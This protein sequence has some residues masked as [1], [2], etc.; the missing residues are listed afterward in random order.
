MP[1]LARATEERHLAH[2]RQAALEQTY[3]AAYADTKRHPDKA[4]PADW[5]SEPAMTSAVARAL[6]LPDPR[7]T[8]YALHMRSQHDAELRANDDSASAAR[9]TVA[10]R[11]LAGVARRPWTGH[12]PSPG[13]HVSFTTPN[14]PGPARDGV[15]VDVVRHEREG[16]HGP[17]IVI[18]SGRSTEQVSLSRIDFQPA[19]QQTPGRATG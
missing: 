14:L 9:R 7:P 8:L 15:V 16:L 6:A 1:A 10:V 12:I 13:D 19:V 2:Q 11:A 5:A 3:A 18:R 17:L 4:A